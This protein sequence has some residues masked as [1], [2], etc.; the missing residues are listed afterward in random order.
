MYYFLHAG[1]SAEGAGCSDKNTGGKRYMAYTFRNKH[2]I[3]ATSPQFELLLIDGDEVASALDI[4]N[5]SKSLKSFSTFA[6]T[7]TFAMRR[8]EGEYAIETDSRV[9]FLIGD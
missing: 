5:Y 7:S 6:V 1:T 9:T 8:G 4:M 2:N 3:F